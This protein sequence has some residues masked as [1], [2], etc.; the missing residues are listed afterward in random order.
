MVITTSPNVSNFDFDALLDISTATAKAVLT[1]ISTYI[2]GGQ[3]NIIGINFKI[4][5]PNNIAF[6]DTVYPP[7]IDLTPGLTDFEVNLPSFN[8]AVKWG[9]YK[10]YA[11]LID[12]DGTQYQ[13]EEN[14]LNYKAIK[15]CKPNTLIGAKGNFG[16]MQL[17]S[18][19]DCD[20]NTLLVEDGTGYV[21][22]GV[23]ATE[24][25]TDVTVTYPVDPTG[26]PSYQTSTFMPF[27]LPISLSGVYSISAQVIQT[28]QY[29]ET[30]SVKV[31]YKY[32]KSTDVQCGFTL[33]KALCEYE[34]LANDIK[35]CVFKSVA[36]TNEKQRQFL[37]ISGLLV[38]I[39]SFGKNCGKTF[40]VATILE[41][42]RE[43]GN[44]TCD[45]DCTPAAIVPQPVYAT[46][47]I[48]KGNMCG[49][50]D[51]V[52]TQVGTSVQIDLSDMHYAFSI[53]EE[54][55]DYVSMTP[56]VV[57]CTTTYTLNIDF[58]AAIEALGCGSS[59]E[60]EESY[61]YI[62]YNMFLKEYEY[63]ITGADFSAEG[64]VWILVDGNYEF[65]GNPSSSAQ[66]IINLN[67]LGLGTFTLAGGIITVFGYHEY[68]EMLGIII[69][70]DQPLM[71]IIIN[72]SNSYSQERAFG[73]TGVDLSDN[74]VVATDPVKIAF[75]I[76]LAPFLCSSWI[77]GAADKY[78]HEI[79]DDS[80]PPPSQYN[81]IPSEIIELGQNPATLQGGVAL[82]D[83]GFGFSDDY[84]NTMDILGCETM[85]N[86]LNITPPLIPYIGGAINYA[87]LD[88]TAS[89]N[90]FVL[91]RDAC[92]AK[93]ILVKKVQ[94][95]LE[96]GVGNFEDI[97]SEGGVTYGKMV[98]KVVP[99]L[100]AIDNTLEIFLDD[101]NYYDSSNP[102]PTWMTDTL[103][104][105]SAPVRNRIKG[106]RQYQNYEDDESTLADA[107]A[108]GNTIN[109]MINYVRSYDADFS[110]NFQQ[111]AIKSSNPL[112]STIGQGVV[113][114]N[115][116][117]NVLQKQ[118]TEDNIFRVFNF[119]SLRSV[120]NN[121]PSVINPV[122][123]Y[124]ER[125]SKL[126]KGL[127]TPT[128]YFDI[129]G[130]KSMACIH[131]GVLTIGVLNPTL[132]D[133]PYQAL[134]ING[135]Y[136]TD[137]TASAVYGESEFDT[138]P[139]F[140][141]SKVVFKKLSFT[142]LTLPLS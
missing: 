84:I 109:D 20:T 67:T 3:A 7:D 55:S 134:K 32:Q 39:Y 6:H 66:L 61:D 69:A 124:M 58:C 140:S 42:I 110:I 1:D 70:G 2:S 63:D 83:P 8:G 139:L 103:A 38:K 130:V 90:E 81:F 100:D 86:V 117:L 18:D 35:N 13:W 53:P 87:A 102:W 40:N 23:V 52:L 112:R 34:K 104:Q 129:A 62:G 48:V 22:N 29:T 105:L 128:T 114:V 119:Q 138:S 41:E 71:A 95:G 54:I 47:T 93:G 77:G 142:E 131:D 50:I 19:F 5:D 78:K 94:L 21:Y 12:E 27:T 45:C 44:F 101:Y 89:V 91:F 56:V 14:G 59:P 113:T 85:L 106:I 141:T 72:T 80:V 74:G 118:I 65:V 127:L 43:I 37:L 122:Y 11:T 82:T 26:T 123:Y 33:C 120:S 17:L 121:F 49:D 115:S 57:G 24:T 46:G 75:Y 125:F 107:L 88:F 60:V 116:F 51:M 73:Y 135:V 16:G 92:T 4:I 76:E 108:F 133:V 15:L 97:Y 132:S 111:L 25:D 28:Y 31:A 9:N 79:P 30:T 137:Y 99:L 36:E 64:M 126:C 98:E 96:Q 10:I 68:G 136:R